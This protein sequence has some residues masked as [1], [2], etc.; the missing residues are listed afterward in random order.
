MLLNW[1]ETVIVV[2]KYLWPFRKVEQFERGVLYVWARHWK[3]WPARKGDRTVGPGIWPV[4]PYFTE[5]RAATSVFGVTGTPLLQI[6]AQDGTPITFSAA[7]TW[8]IYNAA[9][10]WNNV[11]RVLET[12]QE[13][14]AAVTAERLAEV[15][16]HRLDGDHRRRL[17]KSMLKW[18]NEEMEFMGCEATALRFTNFALGKQSVRTLRLMMD[19]ALLTDF[20]QGS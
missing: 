14:L 16:P 17:I 13:L 12:G 11:D 15:K 4:L 6:T 10:A 7:M 8:R 2:I 5:V 3:H 9:H 1:L 18:L 20:N 19:T